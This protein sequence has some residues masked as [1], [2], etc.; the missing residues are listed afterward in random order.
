MGRADISICHERFESFL[1]TLMYEPAKYDETS[2]GDDN[3]DVLHLPHR[4]KLCQS[5]SAPQVS[6][7]NLQ[8]KVIFN[9]KLC[10]INAMVL[11]YP[12]NCG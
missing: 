6:H 12:P 4:V 10:F 1:T 5:T 8:I 9:Y 7:T 11:D 3:I 2:P